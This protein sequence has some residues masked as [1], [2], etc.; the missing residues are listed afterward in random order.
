MKSVAERRACIPL[1]WRP[2]LCFV[3]KF[4]SQCGHCFWVES[5]C[6]LL[7]CLLALTLSLNVFP[8]VG[9]W[10]VRLASPWVKPCLVNG[11][12]V[13]NGF[14]SDDTGKTFQR[15]LVGE[16][17]SPGDAVSSERA[18]LLVLGCHHQ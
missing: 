12:C 13:G 18:L 5:V 14:H 2:M 7:E 11:T 4:R 6:I 15:P 10:H 8:H 1:R 3:S 16:L 9:C 17:Y